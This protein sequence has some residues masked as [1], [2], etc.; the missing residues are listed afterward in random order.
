[1]IHPPRRPTAARLGTAVHRI[2]VSRSTP[3][4]NTAVSRLAGIHDLAYC[5]TRLQAGGS[6]AYNQDWVGLGANLGALAGKAA[7]Y[8]RNQIG[9]LKDALAK[10]G[11][12]VLPAPTAIVDVAMV[13]IS[14]VDL[15][16]GFGP[17]DKG[18]AFKSGSDLLDNV[19]LQLDAAKPDTRDWDGE[20]SKAYAD[21]VKALQD[22]VV[23]VQELDKQMQQLVTQQ[24]DE[25]QKAHNAIAVTL[26]GLVIAQG[27]AL[28]LYLIP[29]FGPEISCA[30]QIIAAFAAGATVLAFEMF[31]LANSMS[32]ANDVNVAAKKYI[33]IGQAAEPG[34]SFATIEVKGA[35]EAKVG[36]FTAISESMAGMSAFSGPPSVARLASMAG[37]QARVSMLAV[38]EEEMITAAPKSLAAG[39]VASDVATTSSPASAEVPTPTPAPPVPTAPDTPAAGPAPVFTPPSAAQASQASAQAAKASANIAQPLNVANQSVSQTMQSVQQI[40]SMAQQGE[41]AGTPVADPMLTSETDEAEPRDEDKTTLAEKVEGAAPGAGTAERAPVDAV[42][43]ADEAEEPE[44]RRFL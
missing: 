5:F 29:I 33:D 13:V 15:F 36:S 30:W 12:K 9:V 27:I 10:S 25:V 41:G 19:K 31:T 1:M 4:G 37:P 20:A 7:W 26:L 39:D 22:L 40:V 24:G 28:A 3:E 17:P 6:S 42:A 2:G 8:G 23:L 43:P 21:A 38:A 32:L 16:N 14:A 44:S 35:E 11:T 34:G 18:A